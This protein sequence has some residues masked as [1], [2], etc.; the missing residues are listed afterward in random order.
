MATFTIQFSVSDEHIER[1]RSALRKHFGP[2]NENVTEEITN[3]ETGQIETK[4]ILVSRELTPEELLAKVRQMSIDNI[5]AIVMSVEANEAIS[6]AKA[7]V[8]AVNVE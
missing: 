4:T 2:V 5:K 6:L 1:I 3:S 7:S 8:D